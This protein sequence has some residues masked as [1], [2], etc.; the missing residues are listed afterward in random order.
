LL[1]VVEVLVLVVAVQVDFAQVQ[2]YPLY[3]ELHIR[4]RLVM[5]VQEEHV[6]IQLPLPQFLEEILQLAHPLLLH[7]L[8][9]V[10][11]NQLTDVS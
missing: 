3:P 9:V 11:V 8:V 6:V 5:V 1:L 4:L 2:V 7:R 10:M